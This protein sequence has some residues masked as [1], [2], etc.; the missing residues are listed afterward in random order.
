MHWILHPEKAEGLEYTEDGKPTSPWYR[1]ECA[2]T[3][4]SVEIAQEIDIDFSGSNYQF[5]D[6]EMVLHL[7]A[8]T[9]EPYQVGR[10]DHD[11]DGEVIQFEAGR[12]GDFRLWTELDAGGWPMTDRHYVIGADIAAGTGSSNST[13]CVFDVKEGRKIAEFADPHLRPD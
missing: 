4:N 12:G 3:V 11:R 6:S 8:T 10:L 5:F 1:A 7:K 2:R 13:L 9:S